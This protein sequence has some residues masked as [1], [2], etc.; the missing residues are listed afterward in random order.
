MSYKSTNATANFHSS[1][2][3][4]S[5][6]LIYKKNLIEDVGRLNTHKSILAENNIKVFNKRIKKKIV[7]KVKSWSSREAIAKESVQIDTDL[8]KSLKHLNLSFSSAEEISGP[9]IHEEN[10]VL[11]NFKNP[12]LYLP[13]PKV[14]QKKWTEYLNSSTILCDYKSRTSST[15]DPLWNVFKKGCK[16]KNCKNNKSNPLHKYQSN[17]EDN[18]TL[19]EENSC[20]NIKI[21]D[22]NSKNHKIEREFSYK[23]NFF[24]KNNKSVVFTNEV[25]VIYFNGDEVICESK[26]PLKKDIEQQVRNKEMRHG[27]LLKTQEKYNLCLF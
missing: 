23:Y 6:N 21:K 8:C 13:S 25:F 27:H 3:I 24:Q 15:S 11:E 19:L 17:K 20:L 2:D 12:K 4:N 22:K 1:S 14:K 7:E 18:T 16:I 9:M 26:E 10:E 5:Q